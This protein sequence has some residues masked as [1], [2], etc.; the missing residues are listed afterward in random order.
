MKFAIII[1]FPKLGHRTI[2]LEATNNLEAR[3]MAIAQYGAENVKSLPM[4]R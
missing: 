3:A 1:K 4:K 2:T